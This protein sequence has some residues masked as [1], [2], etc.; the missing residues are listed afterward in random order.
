MKKT[1]RTKN[2]KL[3]IKPEPIRNLTP[4]ELKRADGGM[5]SDP[6]INDSERV[7]CTC[8]ACSSC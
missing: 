5:G 2:K 6:C 1:D 7:T 8:N 4:E 3:D